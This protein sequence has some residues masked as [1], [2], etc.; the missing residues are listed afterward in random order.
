MC[1][2]SAQEGFPTDWHFRHYAERAVGGASLIILEA[3]A[4]LPEGRIS[5]WDLGLW[6]DEHG[7]ALARLVE[8]LH[9]YGAKVG[10]QLAHAGRKAS[11]DT[12]WNG[13]KFLDPHQGG[14]LTRAPSAL[15]F[16]AAAST[17]SPLSESEIE[18]TVQA[19][20]LAAQR[21]HLAGFD[22]VEIHAAHG[23][24]LHQFLSPLS[25]QRHDNWGG[26]LSNRLRLSLSV[27]E[28][29]RRVWPAE[30]PLLARVSATDWA[31]GGWNLEDTVELA[32]GW[33]SLGVDLVDV[34]SG[35]L[36]P[37]AQIPVAPGYQVPFSATVRE[38]AGLATGAV[39][40]LQDVE[41]IRAVIADQKADLI[42]L[43]RQLLRD[44]YWPLR[45]APTEARKVP[46]QYQRAF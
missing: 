22:T 43:G 34:S 31:E 13:G 33:K 21:A 6:D 23:Y 10:V 3:T 11:T 14:W 15:A 24:L 35:G 39:G 25:N 37:N 44:P 16:S 20:A 32:R 1:Q 27:A 4:V 2:Y 45:H 5:P 41:Q 46:L 7:R 12:P 17:P 18:Q 8:V 19:F 30:K 42:F 26:R 28:A 40:L 38:Q 36:I 29:I 9:G